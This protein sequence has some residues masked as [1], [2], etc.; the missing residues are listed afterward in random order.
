MNGT[1][2]GGWSITPDFPAGSG[3]TTGGSSAGLAQKSV[4]LRDNRW[5][6]QV[7]DDSIGWYFKAPYNQNTDISKM[8]TRPSA[9]QSFEKYLN[10]LSQILTG[11]ELKNIKITRLDITVD[12]FETLENVLQ[13]LNVINKQVEVEYMEKASRRTGM[14][15]GKGSEIIVVYD[16]ADRSNRSDPLT[17]IE[18]QIAGKKLPT[19]DIFK[20]KESLLADKGKSHFNTLTL[21]HITLDK[22]HDVESKAVHDR[23]KEFETLL[24]HDGYLSARKKLNENGN[25]KRDYGAF[26]I[27]DP[28]DNQPEKVFNQ[29]M[30]SFFNDV[31]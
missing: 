20:L 14:M 18:L 19:R 7:G 17:R 3:T 22:P 11:N 6:V 13:S 1:V 15:I 2:F 29:S 26:F 27:L 5:Y 16:K 25:F 24:K 4:K 28:W 23:F 10:T 31:R 30:E 21:N 9:F 8:I 12:Y